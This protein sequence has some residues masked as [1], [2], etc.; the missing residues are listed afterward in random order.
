MKASEYAWCYV[1]ANGCA[2]DKE[3]GYGSGWNYYGGR[4]ECE[5][6]LTLEC[7]GD[8]LA[9]GINWKLTNEPSDNRQSEFN[10]TFDEPTD[11][12]TL[13]GTMYTNSGGKYRWGC[14]FEEPTSV[15]EVLE[16]MSQHP[17]IEAVV[18][19]RLENGDKK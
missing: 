8:I 17:S 16:Y 13:E 15:F 14:L 6:Q 5:K 18:T 7:L 11:M 3:Q 2:V 10:S 9:T 4:F 12:K 1:L 19:N